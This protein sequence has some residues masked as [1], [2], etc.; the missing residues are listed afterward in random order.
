MAGVDV[1]VEGER[2]LWVRGG[3]IS[4]YCRAF[5]TGERERVMGL[6]WAKRS[7][8]GLSLRGV[9]YLLVFCGD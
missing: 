8:R 7:G 5:R 2:T 4:Y 6:D 9:R 3:G 1:C